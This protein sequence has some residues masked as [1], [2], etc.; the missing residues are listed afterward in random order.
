MII[1][2]HSPNKEV[3]LSISDAG[4]RGKGRVSCNLYFLQPKRL[5]YFPFRVFFFFLPRKHIDI[6]RE[7]TTPESRAE[8]NG[9]TDFPNLRSPEGPADVQKAET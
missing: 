4:R 6:S 5:N 9:E 1:I 2:L 3:T 7:I 8:K